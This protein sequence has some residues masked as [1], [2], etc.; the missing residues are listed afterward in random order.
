[1]NNLPFVAALLCALSLPLAHADEAEHYVKPNIVHPDYGDLN[2]VMP[3]S[4]ADPESWNLR[5]QHAYN[6]VMTAKDWNGQAH[7]VIVLYGAGVKL[8]THK[9]DDLAKT[10]ARLRDAGITFKVC[11]NSMRGMNLDWH[12]LNG[13]AEADIVPAGIL[14]V[15]YLERKGYY[16]DSE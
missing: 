1:M 7:V 13:V 4:L 10:V 9:D 16:M 11:N 12:N 6:A 3:I 15:P 2:I 14:E 8:L 5:M